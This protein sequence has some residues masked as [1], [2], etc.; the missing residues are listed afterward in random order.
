MLQEIIPGI[1][2]VLLSPGYLTWG[3]HLSVEDG[4]LKIWHAMTTGLP[5]YHELVSLAVLLK[6]ILAWKQEF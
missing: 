2:R 4:H 5:A 6:Y 3:L 1:A